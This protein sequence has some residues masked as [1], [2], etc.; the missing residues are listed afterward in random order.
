MNA[1]KTN[2]NKKTKQFISV[3]RTLEGVRPCFDINKE[4]M[5]EVCVS[6]AD[7]LGCSKKTSTV[8]WFTIPTIECENR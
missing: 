8:I 3:D 7:V 4:C 2:L 1:E 5:R 6:Y